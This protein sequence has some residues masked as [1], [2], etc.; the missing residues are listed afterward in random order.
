[1]LPSGL[2][3]WSARH[4]G[5]PVVS[6]VL[7]VLRGSASDPAGKEGLAALTADMLDEGSGARSA[8]EMH[9]ALARIGARFDTDVGPDGALVAITALGRFADRALVLLA[10]MV[11]RPALTEADFTRVRQLRL[12]RLIQLRDLPGAVAD[13]AFLRL[14]YGRHP[15]GH[16]PIGT[17][18]ALAAL[19]VE[20]VRAFHAGLIR[21]DVAILVAVG[22]CDHG[23][24]ERI[25]AEAF[26]GWKPAA[27]AAVADS[28]RTTDD[29]P[30]A[31]SARLN[32]VP[33]PGAPQS[34]LRIG[35]VTVARDTPDYYALVTANMILGGQFV[36][37]INLN[38][39]EDK[40][41]TYGA[42]TAFDFRRMAGPFSLQAS[43]ETSA[44][45]RAIEESIAE[46]AGLLGP[47]PATS[48]EL[49]SAVAALTR[50]FARNFETAD[51]IA[52]AVVQIALYDLSDDYYKEF[53]PRIERITI[54]DVT[55]AMA[56][57]VD[58]DRL[59][60][61][62]VGDPEAVALDLRSL[63]LA[64]PAVLPLDTL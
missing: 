17:E 49:A 12:H 61:L 58:P 29:A 22:A 28:G 35:Q 1:V 45:A 34:E 62:I 21:P 47:R 31:I 57:H 64:E 55:H 14:L 52:R 15:Y 32:I 4:S 10:D 40:G 53:V 11:A 19:T 30:R 46:I 38:L 39:R 54:D 51:Q 59:V 50:G 56:K 18:Q 42:R 44:T 23:R 43:V 63:G 16:A 60:T 33:R 27:A 36:S 7:L 3:I 20:D 25:A 24:I 13:R 5:V 2:R 26:G 41:F 8:I 6:F 37:R 9:E 48:E